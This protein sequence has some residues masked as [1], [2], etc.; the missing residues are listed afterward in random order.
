[1]VASRNSA[2]VV[3]AGRATTPTAAN[4]AESSRANAACVVRNTGCIATLTSMFEATVSV[5]V[6]ASGSERAVVDGS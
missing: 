3:V 4:A 5:S 6:A 1:L 2:I